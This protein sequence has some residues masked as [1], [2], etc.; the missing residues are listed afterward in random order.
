MEDVWKEA[1]G[2]RPGRRGAGDE[3]GIKIMIKMWI[4]DIYKKKKILFSP[5]DGGSEI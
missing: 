1:S 2:G 3:D 5:H 4:Q